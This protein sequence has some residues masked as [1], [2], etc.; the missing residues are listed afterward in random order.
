MRQERSPVSTDLF[1]V[2]QWNRLRSVRGEEFHHSF[3]GTDAHGL[4]PF[5]APLFLSSHQR[6]ECGIQML[7]AGTGQA[8]R[9]ALHIFQRDSV[10][11]LWVNLIE[12][13]PQK[14]GVHLRS[15]T[16]A[17]LDKLLKLITECC[18]RRD[19]LSAERERPDI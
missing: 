5:C 1:E 8:F 14:I 7:T 16:E 10:D 3:G 18:P 19:Q 15:G 9:K 6:L 2:L 12:A 17:D 13:R 11:C 4:N